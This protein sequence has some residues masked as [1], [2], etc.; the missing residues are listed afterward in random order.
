MQNEIKAKDW[1]T[2]ILTRAVKMFLSQRCL[3]DFCALVSYLLENSEKYTRQPANLMGF[4][5]LNILVR[6]TCDTPSSPH[7]QGHE[8]SVIRKLN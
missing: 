7:L 1:Y 2:I 3:Q 4:I 8:Y 5:S 6:S